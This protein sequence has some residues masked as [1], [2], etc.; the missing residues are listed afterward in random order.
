[1]YKRQEQYLID[2]SAAQLGP[3]VL[4][5]V[6]F[7]ERY[8]LLYDRRP[9]GADEAERQP[10]LRLREV[11]P[12]FE[13]TAIDTYL[14]TLSAEMGRRFSARTFRA[15]VPAARCLHVLTT[16]FPFFARWSHDMPGKYVWQR[17]N[18]L[19]EAELAH[20]RIGPMAGMRPYL[21]GVFERFLHAYRSL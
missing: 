12:L 9:D 10:R 14:L 8:P 3:G 15:A 20:Y 6:S 17:V 19:S 13:E 18:R 21:A 7:V 16:W 11:A 2:W 5:L 1:M 4:D